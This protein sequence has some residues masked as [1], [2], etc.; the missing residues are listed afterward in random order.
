[1][2]NIWSIAGA[3]LTSLGGA[4]IIIGAIVKFTS[5]QIAV[6]LQKKYEHSL[7]KE[8]QLHKSKLEGKEYVSKAYFDREIQIYQEVSKTTFEMV[9]DISVMIP[10]GYTNVPADRQERLEADKKHYEKALES[11][12]AAQD[13]LNCNA[14]FVSEEIFNLCQ[15]I[16]HLCNLQLDEYQDRFVVSDLRPQEEKESFSRDAHKRTN[17][18]NEKYKDFTKQVRGY[19][20]NLEIY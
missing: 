5:S 12:V 8:L 19:L 6:A 3:I 4:A 17:E 11:L 14:P 7:E 9:R 13:T 1:M 20:K 15:E 10:S 16:R 2:Q 18:I